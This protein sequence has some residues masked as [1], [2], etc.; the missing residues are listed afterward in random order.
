MVRLIEMLRAE[1]ANGIPTKAH[2]FEMK[3]IT[4]PCFLDF[5]DADNVHKMGIGNGVGVAGDAGL[6]GF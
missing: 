1:R 2:V 6:K 4:E 3:Y 5:A